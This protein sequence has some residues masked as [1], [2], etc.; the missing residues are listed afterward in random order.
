MLLILMVV[1]VAVLSLW[2]IFLIGGRCEVIDKIED[3]IN[4]LETQPTYRHV[5]TAIIR[6]LREIC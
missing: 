5:R 1:I 6:K 2:V 4:E 3:L